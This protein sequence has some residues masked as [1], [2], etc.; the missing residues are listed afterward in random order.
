[1]Q[2]VAPNCSQVDYHCVQDG[3]SRCDADW[4]VILRFH[5]LRPT[6]LEGAFEANSAGSGDTAFIA[7]GTELLMVMKMGLAEFD[8]LVDLKGIEDLRGISVE[9]DGTLRIGATVTHREIERSP[10]VADAHP[11]LARLEQGVA[12]LRVRNTGT[13]GG[14]LAFA[15]PHSDPATLLLVCD[16]RVELA[17]RGGRR[18]MALGEFTLGPLFTAREPD[19][20]LVAIRIPPREAGESTAYAR[21]KFFERPAVS[22]AVRLRVEKGTIVRCDVAVGSITEVPGTV[23]GAGAAL[24][25]APASSEDLDAAL[26]GATPALHDLDAVEDHNGSADYKRHLSTVLLRRVAHTALDE[27]I[28]RA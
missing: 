1:M 3:R 2:V 23:P 27:A 6:D 28:A 9:A 8:T 12:N 11:A 15:E 13:L 4:F 21:V 16:A 10:V 17:G 7:G 18:E 19:E 5:L 14:N 24:V 22:V 25:G 26:A 20:I